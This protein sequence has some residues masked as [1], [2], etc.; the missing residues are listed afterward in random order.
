MAFTRYKQRGQKWYV[1]QVSNVWDKTLKKY[2]QTSIYLGVANEKG[3]TYSKERQQVQQIERE[4]LD[5]G[6][7]F[8]IAKNAEASGFLRVLKECFDDVDSIMSLICYQLTNGAAMY[9]CQDWVEGNIANKLFPNAKLKSQS[10]SN[11]IKN[12][13]KE[14][15]QRKFFK[16]YIETF[17][18][19]KHGILIDGTALPSAVNSSL[20]AW[21]Y[22]TAGIQ[23]KINCLMLVDKVSKLP[24]FFRAVPGDIPDVSTLKHTFNEIARLGLTTEAAI[25]D[26]GYFSQNNIEYLCQQKV[27]FISRM[28]KSR[29]VFKDLVS[30]AKNIETSSH[31]VQY[32]KRIVFIDSQDI[33]LYGYKMVAHVILDPEKKAKDV[34]LLLLDSLANPDEEK[35]VD[36]A[37]RYCGFFILI[38]KQE[39]NKAEVLPNYYMRQSI[40]QIFGFAKIN[41]LLPLRVHSDQ[42]ISGYLLLVFLSIIVFIQMRQKL[43]DKTTVEQALLVLRNLKAKVYDQQIIPQELTKK[44]K[45]IFDSLGVTVPTLL[46]I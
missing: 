43:E 31:A 5:F 30:N 35:D 15:V 22:D 16:R 23:K 21:G 6:D 32:G 36:E 1:Y 45:V 42:S 8:A 9:N 19:D 12:L 26:A 2:K 38:S 20:N 41:N 18:Q 17:F 29:S 25:F 14:E 3:G 40:E 27:N 39:L 11:L 44:T 28:P 10:I 7:S 34:K 46:G 24:I 33:N 13:G 37:M 4:I